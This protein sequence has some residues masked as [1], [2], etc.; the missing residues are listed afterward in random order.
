M[1]KTFKTGY[2]LVT[3][4]M[5]RTEYLHESIQTWNELEELN[6]IV[7]VDYSS[8]KPILQSDLPKPKFGKKIILVRVNKE[9]MWVLSHAYN[10]GISF[11]QYDKLLKIDSDIK[12]SK[13]F[14]RSHPLDKNKFY[15]GN[16]QHAR[17]ENE[18]HFN[19]QLICNTSDFFA[20]NGY[21][22]RI[23]TYGYD[24][25][26]LYERLKNNI[27][28]KQFNF[29]YDKMDHIES[30]SELRVKNQDII[31]KE[32]FAISDLFKDQKI[33]QEIVN[34]L[35]WVPF[36][37]TGEDLRLF[38]ETQINRIRCEKNPWTDVDQKSKWKI[39]QLNN[40]YH[41]ERQK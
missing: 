23:I 10:L 11:A 22:E 3:C 41:C 13:D 17:N 25:T 20:V 18:I 12:L 19:G 30:D 2:S 1:K 34:E 28:C 24:D 32:R 16:W 5:N 26:D 29:N 4:S 7:V 36:P 40:I 15:C 38:L 35:I 39:T 21:D 31:V 6:E 9:K 14:I 33:D 27:Q 8:E 37:N